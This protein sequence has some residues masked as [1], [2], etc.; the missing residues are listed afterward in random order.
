MQQTGEEAGMVMRHDVGMGEGKGGGQRESGDGGGAE[1]T[2]DHRVPR[3]VLGTVSAL[4]V[5][6]GFYPAGRH[7]LPSWPDVS[8]AYQ[9]KVAEKNL[10]AP[11]H[12][13]RHCRG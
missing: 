12:A 9:D 8:H 5:V 1:N 6:S 10:A 3:Q 11:A 4:R 13:H 7:V 2:A